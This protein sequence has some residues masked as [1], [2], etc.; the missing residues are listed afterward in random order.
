MNKVNK[1]LLLF[2]NDSVRKGLADPDSLAG[3]LKEAALSNNQS[4]EIYVSYAR[5]LSF[6]ITNNKV[7][8]RDHRNHMNLED[9]DFVY[10]R[11]AGSAMQQMLTCALYLKDHGIPFFDTEIA[12]TTSRNKLSQMYML[13]RRGVPIPKTLY[14]RNNRRLIRL[15]SKSHSDDFTFPIIAKATGG[16]R[17]DANYLVKSVEEL[18]RILSDEKRHFIIQEFIPNDGDLRFFISGGVLKGIIKRLSVKGSHLNNTSKGGSA[19]L[20]ALKNVSN[21]MKSSALHSAIIFGRDCAGVDIIIDKNNGKH[22]IL[23]VNRA[24]QIEHA[25][26]EAEKAEWMVEAIQKT[27]TNFQ[28]ASGKIDNNVFG[29]F[30]SVHLM[31]SDHTENKLIAKVDTGADSS[32]LHATDVKVDNNKL[33]CIIEGQ[34]AYF[35]DYIDRKVRSSNGQWQHR[36]L[37]S[38]PVRIGEVIYNMKITLTDRSDMNYSMLIGRRF[39]R[40][41]DLLVDVGRRYIASGKKKEIK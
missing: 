37:V 10:F 22:Y 9:Y 36:Y 14:C 23:E 18:K 35:D 39:L 34:K 31:L 17:G 24:P 41:N 40:A 27:I 1:V 26:F 33:S 16:T 4:V 6:L 2:S 29:R 13:Q 28:S 21:A 38:I 15:I 30:E 12:K 5:S 7:K 32:S 11:K 25:S 19:E 20:L 8:I 3:L